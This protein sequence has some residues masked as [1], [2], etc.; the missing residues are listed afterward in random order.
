MIF[1]QTWH[2]FP[3]MGELASEDAQSTALLR[4]NWEAIRAARGE[5]P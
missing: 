4:L 1:T 2:R 5:V 3:G